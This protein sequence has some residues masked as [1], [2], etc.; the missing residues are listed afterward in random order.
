M[1]SIHNEE[2]SW[3]KLNYGMILCKSLLRLILR[4]ESNSLNMSKWCFMDPIRSNWC[5]SIDLLVCAMCTCIFKGETVNVSKWL[6]VVH[7]VMCEAAIVLQSMSIKLFRD[8]A[9]GPTLSLTVD[10][11]CLSC[12]LDFGSIQWSRCRNCFRLCLLLLSTLCVGSHSICRT[13]FSSGLTIGCP[14]LPSHL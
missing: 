14:T 1:S 13:W 6:S 9:T 7:L 2:S 5:V 8:V 4:V 10:H 3:G 11:M 12:S